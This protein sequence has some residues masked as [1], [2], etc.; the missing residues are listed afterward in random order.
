M[1]HPHSE[2]PWKARQSYIPPQIPDAPA[3]AAF[4]PQKHRLPLWKTHPAD[5]ASVHY[6]APTRLRFSLPFHQPSVSVNPVSQIPDAPFL[7]FSVAA[8]AYHIHNL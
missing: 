8:S 2:A 7:F 6:A 5:S 3:V 4:L 1:P